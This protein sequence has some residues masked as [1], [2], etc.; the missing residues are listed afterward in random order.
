MVKHLT[1]KE[2]NE[3]SIRLFLLESYEW[4]SENV[5]VLLA[6]LGVI[7]LLGMLVGVWQWHQSGQLAQ[8][9]AEFSEALATFNQPII[10]QEQADSNPAVEASAFATEE[11]RDQA[12]LDQFQAL[13]QAQSGSRLGDL[14]GYFSGLS[15]RRLGQNESALEIFREV[16]N[17][18]TDPAVRALAGDQFA[19]V[20]LEL[21]RNEEAAE[22]WNR[23]LDEPSQQLPRSEIMTSLA[24]AYDEA[25]AKDEALEWLKQLQSGFPSGPHAASVEARIALLEGAVE[26]PEE[27][28]EEEPEG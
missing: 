22:A 27:S 26:E 2:I 16:S 6:G 1:R 23:L 17:D 12:A 3:D 4:L 25:G 20:A 21:G 10:T 19:Q 8:A 7:V 18:A 15:Q 9:N 5:R 24:F 13:R 11:E 14:A 28:V